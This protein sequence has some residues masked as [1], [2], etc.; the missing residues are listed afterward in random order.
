MVYRLKKKVLYGLK[1]AP[2]AWYQEI[3]SY[4]TANRFPR[5][6]NEA[7]FYIKIEG[8]PELIV[9]LYVDDVV[10]TRNCEK[11]LSDFKTHMMAKYEMS[12]LGLRHHFLDISVIQTEKSVFIHQRKYVQ[13]PVD[14][15]GLKNYMDQICLG[16][17]G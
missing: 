17:F 5:R 16:R 6:T 2:E 11:M 13:T 4:F 15:F 8:D 9:S 12:N 1:Q 3:Y 14:K 7:T 10:Y